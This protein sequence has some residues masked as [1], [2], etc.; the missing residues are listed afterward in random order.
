MLHIFRLHLK[1]LPFAMW[2]SRDASKLFKAFLLTLRLALLYMY[3]EKSHLPNTFFLTQRLAPPGHRLYC[4]DKHLCS[5]LLMSRRSHLETDCG[6]TAIDWNCS[7]KIHAWKVTG[8][9]YEASGLLML[10]ATHIQALSYVS[11]ALPRCKA[12]AFSTR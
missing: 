11:P 12:Q 4:M 9:G 5:K 1:M 8:D 10:R 3:D 7:M 2:C 6:N